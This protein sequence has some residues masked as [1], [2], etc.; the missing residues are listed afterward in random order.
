MFLA[1]GLLVGELS[2]PAP[3]QIAERM[4]HLGAR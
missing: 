2:R 1:D 4:T 3:A